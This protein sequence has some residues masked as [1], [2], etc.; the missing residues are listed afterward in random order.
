MGTTKSEH[1]LSPLRYFKKKQRTR[2]RETLVDSDLKYA[3]NNVVTAENQ[4]AYKLGADGLKEIVSR[5][6]EEIKRCLQQTN[7]VI[8][9]R[10]LGQFISGG[11]DQ[12]QPVSHETLRK[13]AM[14]TTEFRYTFTKT[15][16]QCAT[17]AT[18]KNR[19]IWAIS[20]HLFWE[21]AKMVSQKVQ[22]VLFH[23]DEKWFMALVKRMDNKCV[24][25]FG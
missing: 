14:S 16:P 5:V 9:W 4:Y 1:Y 2:H 6:H 22:V 17:K 11:E 12:V 20:F 23:A 7:G 25:E 10:R 19:Y 13:F 24:P 21:G 18:K 3:F 15:L 8:S